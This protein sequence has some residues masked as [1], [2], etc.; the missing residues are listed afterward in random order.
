MTEHLKTSLYY[1]QSNTMD[2]FRLVDLVKLRDKNQVTIP[3]RVVRQ[4]DL[5]I[6][7]RLKV[8]CDSGEGEILLEVSN[9]RDRG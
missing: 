8:F 5:N 2:S 3:K 9:G 4:L 1:L 7:S 6:G